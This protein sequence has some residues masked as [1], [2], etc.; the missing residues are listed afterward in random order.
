MGWFQAASMVKLIWDIGFDSNTADQG[1]WNWGTLD[2]VFNRYN[3][4]LMFSLKC[5]DVLYLSLQRLASL[6]LLNVSP[7]SH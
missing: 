1:K 4:V 5:I 3:A 7:V 6:S 2:W